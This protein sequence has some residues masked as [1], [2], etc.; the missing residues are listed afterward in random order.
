[1]AGAL[2]LVS[3]GASLLIVPTARERAA[4]HLRDREFEAARV[5][6]E[7]RLTREGPQ[8]DNVA[9]L[10]RL[11]AQR[12]EL[13]RAIAVLL[14]LIVSGA[15]DARG[16]VD[17]RRLLSTY[18]KWAGRHVEHRTNLA[19][20]AQLDP[21]PE[22][23]RELAA[24]Y[25]FEGETGAQIAVLE[26]LAALPAA[27]PDDFIDLAE[28]KAA[29]RDFRGAVLA[30]AEL[31]GRMPDKVD[32]A[33]V[34]LWLVVALEA[35]DRD[36]AVEVAR[37]H[38]AR[39]A[40]PVDVAA[41]VGAFAAQRVPQLGLAA[42]A[43]VESRLGDDVA[44]N[45]ALMRLALDAG[46]PETAASLFDRQLAGGTP[47]VAPSRIGDLIDVGLAAGRV[48]AALAL[49]RSI[50]VGGLAQSQLEGVAFEALE[51]RRID[52]LRVLVAAGGDRL[53]ANP[54][55]A[56]RVH[57]ELGDRARALAAAAR[58]AR[59]TSL[60]LEASLTVVQV[61][62]GAGRPADALTLLARVADDPA[63][64]ET[65]VVDMAQLYLLL[66][67]A[68]DGTAVFERLR[69]R[70]P[71]SLAAATGWALVMA[72]AGR[73]ETV[74][75][76]LEAAGAMALPGP[77]LTDLFF[78]G[79]D[80]R[81]PVLQLA[82][83]RR[84]LALEGP[85][86]TARL[87][88]AQAALAAGRAGE[89]LA[90]ARGLRAQ[91]GPAEIETLY[92]DAMF[93]AARTDPAA[94]A[95]LRDYWRARLADGTAGPETRE[96]ALYA[97][98]EARD[99]DTV[100]PDLARR[101]R[102]APAQWLGAFVTASAEA[103]RV[104]GAVPVLLDVARRADLP[105]AIRAEALFALVER[106]PAATH[107]PALERAAAEFGGEWQDAYE[108]ALERLGR[109][110]ALRALVA[111]RAADPA[112]PA[113]TRRALA[114][115]LL[116]LG[117]K[118]AALGVFQ[119]LAEGGRATAADAQQVLF[120]MG[121]RP[122]PAQL[123]WI[124]AQAR[125]AAG[126]GRVEWAR[127]LLDAGA[128][129]RAAFVL[130]AEAAIPGRIGGTA[131]VL[132]AEAY[133]AAGT[134]ADRA[135]LVRILEARIPREG[136]PANARRLGEI[137]FAAGRAGLARA[138]YSR[139]FLLDPA[140]RDAQR[141]LG[142]F[143]FADGDFERARTLLAR[144]LAGAPSAEPTDWEAHYYLGESHYRLR[145]RA[146]AREQHA[147]A[148]AA[149]EKLAQAP[150]AARVAQAY[151][152]HRLGRAEESVTLYARLVREQPQNRDLRAD[153][154]GVLLELGRTAAARSVLEPRS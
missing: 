17:A 67:R 36:L 14:D 46:R 6:Y 50:D 116:D 33:I 66:D 100:L 103:R 139:L 77:V 53:E 99:W 113:D 18:L 76:W 150:F 85:T 58:A 83:A 80:A 45:V 143:A 124:E 52:F 144:F 135:A 51:R 9:P 137:A 93:A 86:P 133:L 31:A 120:L 131:S 154:A 27:L 122:I 2:V 110:D 20:I 69:A 130:E 24:L 84:L 70:R 95:E 78:I 41:V 57:L 3:L 65:A 11:Y 49:A 60:P 114:F 29:R 32:A 152:Y 132:A 43:P 62:A 34:D 40:A 35:G 138:A 28:L 75:R 125:A 48:D 146:A 115:R 153:Y 149:V 89:A 91:G 47:D 16:A 142:L 111:R 56:A 109:R 148:L 81:V 71:D 26:R 147:L 73:G 96:E 37:A 141:Q 82:A 55:L 94:R 87:R 90:A 74:A 123:D 112:L 151:L 8:L 97:L 127:A 140:Q 101:A 63:L 117:D 128:P 4:M 12:G 10:A 15:L 118:P 23:L 108:A 21:T 107:L 19:E 38:L 119:R 5:L 126:P 104:E 92:R 102:E 59:D 1:L 145:D 13:D 105:R 68:A 79:G 72:Q 64:P 98:I 39:R 61:F 129:R 42:L 44:V 88:L 54:L 7:E 134:P 136:E 25:N 22:T 30:L 121:P 106:T